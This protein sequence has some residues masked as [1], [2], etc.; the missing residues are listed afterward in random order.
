MIVAGVT[1]VAG[2]VDVAGV[3]SDG[4]DGSGDISAAATEALG[5]TEDESDGVISALADFGDATGPDGQTTAAPRLSSGLATATT[6]YKNTLGLGITNTLNPNWGK[7]LEPGSAEYWLLEEHGSG[8]TTPYI[9]RL[10]T[11][12]RYPVQRI[13]VNDYYNA[14]NTQE[15][16]ERLFVWE[17]HGSGYQFYPIWESNRVEVGA[18]NTTG[19]A[20][21][22]M[23]LTNTDHPDKNKFVFYY[24]KP[25]TDNYYTPPNSN[26]NDGA[27]KP[28]AWQNQVKITPRDNYLVD[29]GGGN[30][31]YDWPGD[32]DDD[33]VLAEEEPVNVKLNIVKMTNISGN[34]SPLDG[35]TFT[36]YRAP[37][38]VLYSTFPDVT[39]YTS[40]SAWTTA[41]WTV[42]GTAQPSGFTGANFV[43]GGNDVLI[44]PGSYVVKETVTPANYVTNTDTWYIVYS[45]G[46]LKMYLN[47]PTLDL[48]YRND[49]NVPKSTTSTQLDLSQNEVAAT[50]TTPQTITYSTTIGNERDNSVLARI[51]VVKYN[52][53][54]SAEI[55]GQDVPIDSA[56]PEYGTRFTG[57]VYGI[58]KYE[59]D[60][61]VVNDSVTP[62]FGGGDGVNDK[63]IYG[64]TLICGPTGGHPMAD[65]NFSDVEPGYYELTEIKAPDGYA[66]DPTPFTFKVENQSGTAVVT[67]VKD[68]HSDTDQVGY[69]AG[70]QNLLAE[71]IVD[72][73][74]DGVPLLTIKA[75]DKKPE[76]GLTLKKYDGDTQAALADV[77]FE[78]YDNAG[79][80]LLGTYIT[81]APDGLVT[82]PLPPQNGS[83]TIKEALPASLADTYSPAAD[84]MIETRDGSLYVKG[85][86]HNYD[87]KLVHG[88]RDSDTYVILQPDHAAIPVYPGQDG[89]PPDLTVDSSGSIGL[90]SA[91]FGVP[92]YEGTSVTIQGE[93]IVRGAGAPTSAAFTFTL[94]QVTDATGNTAVATSTSKV[95]LPAAAVSGTGMFQFAPIYGLTSKEPTTITNPAPKSVPYE[96]FFKVQEVNGGAPGWIYDTAAY[97]VKVTV[98]RDG[99]NGPLQAIASY[100]SGSRVTFTNSYTYSEIISVEVDKDTIRRTAAAYISTYDPDNY[101]NVGETQE[102]YRYD[103]DFRSTSNIVSDEFVVDDPL[104]AISTNPGADQVRLNGLWTPA[105]WGDA[106]GK[107]NIWYKT[108]TGIGEEDPSYKATIGAG[109]AA[110]VTPKAAKLFPTNAVDGW[111]LWKHIDAH[112]TA[113]YT[114]RGVIPGYQLALPPGVSGGEANDPNATTYITE[115][116]FEYGAVKVGFTSR[117]YSKDTSLNKDY[118]DSNGVIGSD[119]F[120]KIVTIESQRPDVSTGGVLAQSV[121]VIEPQANSISALSLRIAT[122][123]APIPLAA[124]IVPLGAV[125]K[126]LPDWTP[127]AVVADIPSQLAALPATRETSPL[128]PA[129]YLVRTT[130]AMSNEDIVSSVS[131]HIASGLTYDED[132]DRVLTREIGTFSLDPAPPEIGSIVAQDSFV[133][134]ANESGIVLR[135]GHWVDRDGNR[136]RVGRGGSAGTGDV[137]ALGLWFAIMVI[138]LICLILLRMTYGTGKRR[139]NDSVFRGNDGGDVR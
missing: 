107:M 63:F 27:N 56:H 130:R 33:W 15:F 133:N 1:D 68:E 135:G 95:K 83:Y 104:E 101:T 103:L 74:T 84:Y 138:T 120:D 122:Q 54:G 106:D 14:K 39:G 66:I 21:I 24:F 16:V 5:G 119:N 46:E 26:E 37:G 8:V 34:P 121:K 19:F 25:A 4:G 123:G 90:V 86:P 114:A 59:E 13:Y 89:Y 28:G 131:A 23:R 71:T 134:H 52:E 77:S 10:T 108:S 100:P 55:T 72:T 88:E 69:L 41:G 113:E 35:A 96:L 20:N 111:K 38:D 129:T 94:T 112:N 132:Q 125:Q 92:N 9:P 67:F 47:D 61:F 102:M 60:T 2:V 53:D 58:W 99:P 42:A 105:V 115:I 49:I 45:G 98:S 126:G 75:K 85:G 57:A 12:Y 50:Q 48:A 82:I 29:D 22:D 87:F 36:L 136:I 40:D 64:N 32:I 62:G 116:R 91:Q 78:V 137:M 110:G 93:K 139:Q 127:Q 6:F 73:D 65:V 3:T 11:L 128:R 31:H 70:K 97:V 44:T 124:A 118:R 51:R 109:T 80:G 43:N 17:D 76:Y 7:T 30:Y 81:T 18:G 117:N 79:G